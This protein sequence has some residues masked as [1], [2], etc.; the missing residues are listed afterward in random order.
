[1]MGIKLLLFGLA[2]L[3]LKSF[4]LSAEDQSCSLKAR[5]VRTW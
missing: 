5:D 3:C 2:R 1:M 4:H